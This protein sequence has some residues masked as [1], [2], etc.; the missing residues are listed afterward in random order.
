MLIIVKYSE[1]SFSTYDLHK[2]RGNYLM[3]YQPP[4]NEHWQASSPKDEPQPESTYE[5]GYR[6][7]PPQYY[8]PLQ[9]YFTPGYPPQPYQPYAQQPYLM[10]PPPQ[11][12]QQP[13]SYQ[14]QTQPPM[15]YPQQM[16][17]PQIVINNN[18]NQTVQPQMMYPVQRQ[19]VDA[20]IRILYFLLVGWW[21]GIYWVLFALIFCCTII[22][23]PLGIL[24]FRATPAVF[25]LYRR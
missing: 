18:M 17:P 14:Q 23:I 24:M 19:Q 12:M 21:A 2:V 16:M 7:M 15:M 1:N 5:Q 20:W 25:T 10:Q 13:F 22:G 4:N 8:P 6:T 9:N 3:S 11:Y